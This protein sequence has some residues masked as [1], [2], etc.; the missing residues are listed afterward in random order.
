[1]K[2]L[3]MRGSWWKQL[4]QELHKTMSET[5]LHR[6]IEAESYPGYPTTR[7]V[8]DE[9]VLDASGAID[10]PDGPWTKSNDNLPTPEKTQAFL[11]A[12]YSVD[13]SGRPVHPRIAEMLTNPEIGVITGR[14]KYWN[15]GPNRT[16]DPIVITREE[17][18]RILLIK[19]TDNGK[20]ALPGGFVDE[21]E[22]PQD[23]SLRE[24]G[25]EATLYLDEPGTEI[26][27][28]V[29][30]DERTTAN[31]WAET[32]AFIYVV[33]EALPV[34][35]GDD[36]ED[37]R[38]FPLDNLRVLHGSHRMLVNRGLER[39]GLPIPQTIRDTLS[40]PKE[41]LHITVVDAGHMAYDH[42][43]VTDGNDY[44]FV[45]TH[46]DSRFTDEER[47]LHSIDYL[48]KEL[49]HY[50]YL[51]DEGYGYIPRRIDLIDGRVL[52]MDA[53]RV[54]DGWVWGSPSPDQPE[55]A[56]RYIFSILSA[57]DKLQTTPLP[58][59]LGYQEKIEPT[60]ETFWKEGWDDI[61]DDGIDALTQRIDQLS[62]GWTEQ[63]KTWV[64]EFVDDL[65]ELRQYA[66][67]MQR[68]VPLFYAHN[69]AR[70]SNIAWHPEYEPGE[71]VELVDWSWADPAPENADHTMFLI[72]MV[73]DGHD[74]TPFLRYIN[75]DFATLYIGAL[76]GHC[77][78]D[79]RDGSNTVREQQVASASAAHR[80]VMMLEQNS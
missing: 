20:W 50:D 32:T 71:N 31:S 48:K 69:D 54:E 38:W 11:D 60:Y 44:L 4:T 14:G 28:D 25:E 59:K 52:A 8:M 46:D 49:F 58:E 70:S 40:K 51:A 41:D 75:K 22:L 15:W 30:A 27:H 36:A 3:R 10:L 12:G 13:T 68:D 73:K 19:R 5:V 62:A 61:A 33:D 67:R 55:L 76:L 64:R 42:D 29:V 53:F 77:R 80:V 78:W 43:Y 21:D 16:A 6:T 57:F 1:M 47:R 56:Y 39:L 37:A 65:P 72:D 17:R 66:A 23:A 24:L 34:V 45:K 2:P 7:L 74:I 9:V 79:T 63:Q 26:Y 35:A 18:P